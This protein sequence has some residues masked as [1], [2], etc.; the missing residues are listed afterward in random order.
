MDNFDKITVSGT[1]KKLKVMGD[2]LIRLYSS[3][4]N[5]LSLA[6]GIPMAWLKLL[7]QYS[8]KVAPLRFRYRGKSKPNYR[9]PGAF[10]HKKFADNFAIYERQYGSGYRNGQ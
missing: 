10:V 7:Y 4:K 9:R 1:Y 2:E 6:K 3:H 5:E 8:K